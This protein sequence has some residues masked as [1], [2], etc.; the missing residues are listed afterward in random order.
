[1]FGGIICGFILQKLPFPQA[2]SKKHTCDALL[3]HEPGEKPGRP[4]RSIV[5]RSE[6]PNCEKSH[7]RPSCPPK[8]AWQLP[9]A[10]YD[11]S[12]AVLTTSP[13]RLCGTEQSPC[14][15]GPHCSWSWQACAGL[16]AHVMFDWLKSGAAWLN[17]TLFGTLASRAAVLK[18]IFP[19]RTLGGSTSPLMPLQTP[20][21]QSPALLHAAPSLVPPTHRPVMV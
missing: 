18:R 13:G 3:L 6:A 16:L 10:T 7:V 12:W 2:A 19:S 4:R 5:F 8:S 11:A 15:F 9:H 20:P 1:M 17:P 14:S 21:G